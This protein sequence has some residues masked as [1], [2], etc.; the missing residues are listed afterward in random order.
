M[1][2][3]FTL[4][5]IFHPVTVQ[6][7]VPP[8]KNGWI[9]GWVKYIKYILPFRLT[10]FCDY[11]ISRQQTWSNTISHKNQNKRKKEKRKWLSISSQKESKVLAAAGL[12]CVW[13]ALCLLLGNAVTFVKGKARRH[14]NCSSKRAANGGRLILIFSKHPGSFLNQWWI[15]VS[16]RVPIKVQLLLLERVVN[17]LSIWIHVTYWLILTLNSTRPRASVY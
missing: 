9:D 15:Q 4:I 3:E 16:V 13:S 14:E 6:A 17:K 1:L 12:L 2:S 8:T 11:F 5:V 10:L 7:I